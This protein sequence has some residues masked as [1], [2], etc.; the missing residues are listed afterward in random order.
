MLGSPLDV[1][2]ARLDRLSGAMLVD[3]A[4]VGEGMG[5]DIIDGH[6]LEALR[7]LV[8]SETARAMGG[9]PSGWVVSLGSVCRTH[10]MEQPDEASVEATSEAGKTTHLQVAFGM[11]EEGSAVCREACHP[12]MLRP[13]WG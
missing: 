3:G 10:W 5:S 1:D 11:V 4:C 2:P 7:W 8:A 12:G 13:S 6:P 9:L